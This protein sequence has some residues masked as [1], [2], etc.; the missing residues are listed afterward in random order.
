MKKDFPS[1]FPQNAEIGRQM[2]ELMCRLFPICRSITG[3]GV[4]KTLKILGDV[5]PLSI[6]EVPTGTRVFD[7]TIPKEWNINDAYV[8]NTTGEKVIDFT[9]SNLHVLNYSVPVRGKMSLE[10][11]K[12]HLFTNPEHPDW[13]PYRTSYYK[14]QWGFCLSHNQLSAMRDG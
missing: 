3:D 2:H 1:I 10:Q 4:R 9:E 5:I 14:E 13:I 6:R 8:K 12:E 11:L 7:W